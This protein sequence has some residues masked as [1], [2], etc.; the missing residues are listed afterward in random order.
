MDNVEKRAGAGAEAE[1]MLNRRHKNGLGVIHLVAA[2]DMAWAIKTL[3]SA[4]ADVNLT[5][6]WG[7]VAKAFVAVTGK[8]I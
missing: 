3:H 8:S 1:A 4:G 7:W 6:Y 5:D 2:L